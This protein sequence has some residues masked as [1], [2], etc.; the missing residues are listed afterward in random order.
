MNPLSMLDVL[1]AGLLETAKRSHPYEGHKLSVTRWYEVLA[2]PIFQQ[3]CNESFGGRRRLLFAARER[4]SPCDYESLGKTYEPY[5]ER[6][7]S[8]PAMKAYFFAL[9]A[10]QQLK[11]AGS[12]PFL[13]ELVADVVYEEL[14][15]QIE[16]GY[17]KV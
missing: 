17:L 9:D 14:A 10:D 3:S 1:H 11:R 8:W 13:N 6:W 12:D 7:Q 4:P 16:R 15:D 5:L 2:D